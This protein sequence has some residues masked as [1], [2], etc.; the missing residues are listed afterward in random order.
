MLFNLFP[1]YDRRCSTNIPLLFL[2]YKLVETAS[3]TSAIN[4]FLRKTKS[5]DG[6]AITVSDVLNDDNLE[7][8]V[9][10]DEAFKFLKQV[11]SSPAFWQQKQRELMSMI[12]QLGCPTFFLTLSAA[13]TK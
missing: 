4:I 1:R 13:E 7:R 9:E 11:R 3:L 2:K 5:S 6:Q 12:R 8:M 10:D